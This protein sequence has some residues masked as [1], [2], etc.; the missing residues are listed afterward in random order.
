MKI[1][2]NQEIIIKMESFSQMLFK[3]WFIDFEFPNEEGQPYKSSGGEMVESEL[4]M[5]PLLFEVRKLED[6]IKKKNKKINI[7]ELIEPINYIGLEHM[8]RASIALNDWETSEKVKGTK[9]VFE[10][11]DILFGKLRPYFRKVGVAPISGV[12]STDILVLNGKREL[13]YYL[14]IIICSS[15]DFIDYATSGSTGTRMPRADWN[16]MNQYEVNLPTEALLMEF[17]KVLEPIINE[18]AELTLQNK[19]LVSLRDILLPKLL[20]GEIEV[21]L[22][23]KV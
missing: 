9:T 10:E 21:P 20:S 7:E 6:L 16:H 12:C 23:E 22:A 3:R 17:N 19:K 2:T 14:L 4:G 18:L 15:K 5:I 11:G 13:Y 8:P 1:N